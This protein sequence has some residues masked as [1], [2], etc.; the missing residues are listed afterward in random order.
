MASQTLNLGM[1]QSMNLTQALRQSINILQMSSIELSEMITSELATNPF[2]EDATNNAAIE[3][4]PSSESRYDHMHVRRVDNDFD[5]IASVADEKT[6]ISHVMEQI[7]RIVSGQEDRIIAS[8]LVNLL[9]ETGYI[10]LDLPLAARNLHVPE[11][12]IIAILH[13]LQTI[14]PTGIFA[15]NLQECLTLQLK[16]RGQY[17]HI[18]KTILANL[19]LLAIHEMQKLAKLCG[20]DREELASY[21]KI[22]KSLDPKPCSSFANKGASN[23]IPDVILSITEGEIKIRINESV[24]PSVHINKEYYKTVKAS[25]LAANDKEFVAT[26]YHGASNVIRAINQRLSTIKEVAEA[27]AQKQRDFFLKGVM[28]LRPMTLSEIA[29]ICGMNESTI[30]R[31][32]TNKYIETPNGIY[33]MKFFFTSKIKSTNSV[34]EISSTKV[35]EIIKSIIEAEEPDAICSDDDI[36]AQLAKF[37]VNIARR[38]VAKYREAMG[39]ETSSMRKRI[40]RAAAS[41]EAVKVPIVAVL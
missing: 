32:T 38:T 27:I 37:N 41:M 31:A 2:L 15:R 14:E 7:G 18:F 25:C 22:I 21:V 26:N 1:R 35:K 23:R 39:I 30:S 11:A 16:E 29:H 4:E 34:S 8:Y 19:P 40:V 24:V 36:A 33:D 17:N 20:I 9:Q 13:K 28:Y 3:N 6:L 10:D 5:S 12:R